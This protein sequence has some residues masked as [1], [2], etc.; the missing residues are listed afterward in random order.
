MASKNLV[1]KS[2]KWFNSLTEHRLQKF[3]N[4]NKGQHTRRLRR[5]LKRTQTVLLKD[6]DTG[7]WY[8]A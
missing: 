8:E 1:E 2:R 4:A 3:A 7:L 6:S 5:S